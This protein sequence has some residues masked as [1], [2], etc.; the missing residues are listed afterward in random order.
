M[1]A[2]DS[3]VATASQRPG[4]RFLDSG[5]RNRPKPIA[6]AMTGTF[7]RN[8][9]CQL[10]CSSSTPPTTGPS[11]APTA[12]IADHTPRAFA[13]SAGSVNRFRIMDSVDGMIM[14]P[15]TPSSARTAITSSGLPAASTASEASPNTANPVISIR[16]RPHRSP[17]ALTVTSS[18]D[19]TSA[20]AS[21]IHSS[22]VDSGRRSSEMAG[23]ATFSTVMSMTTSSTL[24]DSTARPA[25]RLLDETGGVVTVM[26]PPS[27]VRRRAGTC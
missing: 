10:K 15:P 26:V 11:A 16:L 24:A 13:R 14:A 9:A 23:R 2:M 4:A 19:R 22:S 12:A 18:P 20:Y 1:P 17:S 6:R 21:T 5:S 27:E 25:H 7:T 8:A 3:T